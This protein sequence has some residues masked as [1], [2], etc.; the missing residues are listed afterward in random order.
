MNVALII[1]PAI[2]WN[3]P[4]IA[5]PL[6]K[7]YLPSEW[8][9]RIFDL[10]ARLFSEHFCESNFKKNQADF[11]QA[12]HDKNLSKAIDS[13]LL[14]E[15]KI[16]IKSIG[17]ATLQRY[18]LHIIDD[19]FDSNKVNNYLE[20]NNELYDNLSRLLVEF[21]NVEIFNIFGISI[22]IEEQILPSFIICKII[23][24]KYPNA[25]IMLG[26]NI[27]TRLH[28]NIINSV[29]LPYFDMLVLGES[30]SI[31]E[32]AIK[33]IYKSNI[34]N[35]KIFKSESVILDEFINLRTPNFDD[36]IWEE[37]F[38][39]TKVLPLTVQRKCQWGKCDFCS[40][41]SCWTVKTRERKV[42]DVIKDIFELSKKYK[43][44]YFRIVDEMVSVDYLALLSKQLIESKLEIVFEAY[45]RFEQGFTNIETMNTIYKGGCRQLFWGLEN[46]ND[47]ALLFMNKGTNK[48][49]ID[50]I[51]EIS[52]RVG[53]TNYCFLLMGIPQIC[54]ETE[55][56]TIEY[57]INNNNIH[58]GVVGSF[59]IDCLSPI[60][61]NNNM[62]KKYNI[63]LFNAGDLTT[64]VGY[65]HDGRDKRREN[66]KRTGNYICN[67]YKERPD[68]ALCSLLSE[69]A[70]LI[71]TDI[72]GN[73]FARDY[74]KNKSTEKID[75]LVN[76]SIET[77]IENRVSRRI[78]ENK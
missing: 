74:L 78:E 77:L 16:N 4:L 58:I 48:T 1:P 35:K 75:L 32:Q 39:P 19:W 69:E 9:V 8:N 27:V 63:S 33:E 10:N 12:L 3:M 26:G 55:L 49:L 53:I 46:I 68:Y 7:M 44:K 22:T 17:Q 14:M 36:I 18:G 43:V 31:F 24:N 70:R 2:D 71:L 11:V 62:H 29:L 50:N 34:G 23:R 40:I 42:N 47:S 56:E 41:H 76:R 66:K 72:F 21:S 60:H 30:E 15:E 51:L 6:L 45:V 28:E 20:N 38:C 73:K 25:K 37:Y 54:E 59:V 61:V 67:L 13:L 5:F 52:S 64:E 57:A 65:K